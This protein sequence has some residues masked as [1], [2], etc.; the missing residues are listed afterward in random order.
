MARTPIVTITYNSGL[1]GLY[2]SI[3]ASIDARYHSPGNSFKIVSESIQE[4]GQRESMTSHA[5]HASDGV[6]VNGHMASVD[7][8]AT[9]VHI[10]R[11]LK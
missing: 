5:A 2:E 3:M 1:D 11:L 8:G 7:G 6:I 4:A 9:W 10:E